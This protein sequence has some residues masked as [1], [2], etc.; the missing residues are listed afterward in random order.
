MSKSKSSGLPSEEDLIIYGESMGMVVPSLVDMESEVELAE[1]L[2]ALS[3]EDLQRRA[4]N[5][6]LKASGT[7]KILIGNI[8]KETFSTR[9]YARTERK[10]VLKEIG[11]MWLAEQEAAAESEGVEYERPVK[12]SPPKMKRGS[13]KERK[14]S[15]KGGEAKPP[16]KL[17]WEKVEDADIEV[18]PPQSQPP[19]VDVLSKIMYRMKRDPVEGST[20]VEPYQEKEYALRFSKAGG[21]IKKT[22][23]GGVPKDQNLPLPVAPEHV[24]ALVELLGSSSKSEVEVSFGVFKSTGEFVPG[25]NATQF[26]RALHALRGITGFD[27][28]PVEKDTVEIMKVDGV[29]VRRIT[30]SSGV[31]LWER[32]RRDYS[33]AINSEV[34]GYRIVRSSEELTTSS[35]IMGSRKFV[36][37]TTR[38]RTRYTFRSKQSSS[39][40]GVK[41]DL[42]KITEISARGTYHKY[43]VEI[44]RDVGGIR[45]ITYEKFVR[46]IMAMIYVLQNADAPEELM[47]LE[48][49]RAAVGL[50]N[51]LFGGDREFRTKF[52]NATGYR[53]FKDYG[54]KPINVGVDDLLSPALNDYAITLKLDGTR[55]MVGVF[56][57]GSYVYNPPFDMFKRGRGIPSI[58][59]T[60]LDTELHDDSFYAFDILFYRGQDVRRYA[61][62]ERMRMLEEA[63]ATITSSGEF[64]RQ[65]RVKDYYTTGT[66]YDRT[67]KA[68][69]DMA[70]SD[71]EGVVYDGLIFQP[72]SRGVGY[73]NDLTRKWKPES[74]LT[75]DF[76]L[77]HVSSDTSGDTF[78][79][80]VGDRG[81][82]IVFTGTERYPTT[83]KITV[84]DGEH[85]GVD[86][87]GM[88]AE[89]RWITG[90]F[91]IYRLREDRDRPNHINVARDVWRDINEPISDATIRGDTLQAMRRFHNNVK[92]NML[93]GNLRVGDID[94][95]WGSGRGG[96][97]AKWNELKLERVYV[98]EP[99]AENLAELER[100]KASMK[101]TTDVVISKS[102]KRLLGGQ[103]TEALRKVVGDDTLA[104]I[105]SFFSL[106]FFGKDRDMFD[107][108][109]ETISTLIPK[110]GRFVGIVMDGDRVRDLLDDVRREKDLPEEE[111]AVYV[112]E[113]AAFTIEQASEFSDEIEEG[114]NEISITINDPDSMV[115]DQTEW[116]FYFTKLRE[117]LE[118]R[119]FVLVT[120]GY[121]DQ[122]SEFDVLPPSSKTFSAL[123][124]MF[125]FEREDLVELGG[126]K[127]KKVEKSAKKSKRGKSSR[128]VVVNESPVDKGKEKVSEKKKGGKGKKERV[129]KKKKEKV[130]EETFKDPAQGESAILPNPYGADLYN[131]G[132][133]DGSIFAAVLA[134]FDDRYN[135]ATTDSKKRA[136]I[137]KLRKE[138]V[139]SITPEIFA[140]L[141]GGE[142]VRGKKAKAKADALKVYKR[143]IESAD[144]LTAAEV[145]ELMSRVLGYNIILLGED[146]IPMMMG[147]LYDDFIVISTRDGMHYNLVM[148]GD[149]TTL[150]MGDPLVKR[151]GDAFSS[152]G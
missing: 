114:K 77:R 127:K 132:V 34:W 129:E 57:I 22:V 52:H 99:N 64:Y 61:F 36:A 81:T 125:V 134:A 63:V 17:Q 112:P 69:D 95:D 122:G 118:A 3:L 49:S 41:I 58:A 100:R 12:R 91:E 119:G 83:G 113:G 20:R 18:V 62:D 65:I 80:L 33:H 98:V 149:D 93:Q 71:P 73:R 54:N 78:E 88:V 94:M 111:A 128:E 135:A 121:L 120:D 30:K 26:T 14:A 110:K 51:S 45:S 150:R 35:E 126:G 56:D 141:Q 15:K 133:L 19:K 89:C 143:R 86:V 144:D 140:D 75:I 108:M 59:G 37:E 13:K 11:D 131:V 152:E 66:F 32:K 60:L 29:M 142:F 8:V 42:T 103:D 117:A 138:L 97:L 106:T 68:I 46:A 25:V 130:V 151:M 39:Y 53:L 28:I 87:D 109:V 102:G 67:L 24:D 101:I 124:R 139:E 96:D 146:A 16:A 6:G 147:D 55:A 79:I 10:R 72:T 40:H 85:E 2:K 21:V 137:A 43:E 92:R 5:L 123:N 70:K 9:G 115:K 27:E 31:E 76:L 116:L 74:L 50:H 4:Q 48:E 47:T 7:K 148:R 1:E 82:D 38:Q 105:T 145:V 23:I 104:A 84:K 136:R 44:E 107:G 90:H